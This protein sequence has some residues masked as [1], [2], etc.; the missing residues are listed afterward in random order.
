M[1]YRWMDRLE[2]VSSHTV[3]LFLLAHIAV[4]VHNPGP[5]TYKE[6][7]EMTKEGR[8]VKSTHKNSC[9]PE[10]KRS[11]QKKSEE[12]VVAIN[13]L[14]DYNIILFWEG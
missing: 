7:D 10:F 3:C 12:R 5:G 13:Y 11:V 4:K 1:V 8:Y 9:V 2:E 6:Q 14:K